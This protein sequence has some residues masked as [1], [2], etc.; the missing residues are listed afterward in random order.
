MKLWVTAK[1][2]SSLC[3]DG[4]VNN[5][6][7]CFASALYISQFKLTLM[8]SQQ[9]R[10]HRS[11]LS[12][13]MLTGF[14]FPR[15]DHRQF[16]CSGTRSSG[17]PKM[18]KQFKISDDEDTVGITSLVPGNKG[19]RLRTVGRVSLWLARQHA[20]RKKKGARGLRSPRALFSLDLFMQRSRE[21]SAAHVHFFCGPRA[22]ERVITRPR[23]P[24]LWNGLQRKIWETLGNRSDF[25]PKRSAFFQPPILGG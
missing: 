16:F 3:V 23:R 2:S 21:I 1:Q 24:W 20:G 15:P 8:L 10:N 6:C 18:A 14:H 11:L 12:L 22:A 9:S 5:L 4:T 13:R 25:S 7:R 19:S 17:L